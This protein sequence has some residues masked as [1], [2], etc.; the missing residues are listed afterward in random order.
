MERMPANVNDLWN[1]IEDEWKKILQ[2][3]AA[4]YQ[5]LVSDVVQKS[6]KTKVSIHTSY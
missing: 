1:I 2:K 5:G 4:N 6:L 3:F